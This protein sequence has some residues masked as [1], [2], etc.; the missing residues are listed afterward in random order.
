[1]NIPGDKRMAM[2]NIAG[3]MDTRIV[4]NLAKARRKGKDIGLRVR[5]LNVT[6]IL[7]LT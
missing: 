2:G 1:M 7:V 6:S 3:Q 5:M 4:D